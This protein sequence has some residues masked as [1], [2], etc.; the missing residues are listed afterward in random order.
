MCGNDGGDGIRGRDYMDCA[1]G[2]L[3]Q[4]ICAVYLVVIRKFTRN[5]TAP[6]NWIRSVFH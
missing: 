6:V 1:H 4:G 3:T 5:I 2:A